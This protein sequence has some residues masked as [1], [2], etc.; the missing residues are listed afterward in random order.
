MFVKQVR[1]T[2]FK[3]FSDLTIDLS[4]KAFVCTR[5]FRNAIEQVFAGDQE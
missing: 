1:L 5:W 2:N 3:R 4:I